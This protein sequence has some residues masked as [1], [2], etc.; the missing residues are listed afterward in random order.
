[1]CPDAWAGI[2]SPPTAHA[3]GHIYEDDLVDLVRSLNPKRVIPIHTFEPG[4]FLRHF[5][6][7]TPLSDGERSPIG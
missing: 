1:M 3:S 2:K 4:G 5:P 7:A 6:N